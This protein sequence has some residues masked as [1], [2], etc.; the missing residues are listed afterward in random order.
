MNCGS[1]KCQ[2]DCEYKEHK[3]AIELRLYSAECSEVLS[4]LCNNYEYKITNTCETCGC[5]RHNKE[6]E[7]FKLCNYC[8][9]RKILPRT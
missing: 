4:V 7:G 6:L 2:D 9:N 8:Y 3:K 5:I 1:C